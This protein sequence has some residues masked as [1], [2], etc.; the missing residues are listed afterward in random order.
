MAGL[1][2]PAGLTLTGTRADTW[3]WALSSVAAPSYIQSMIGTELYI[4]FCLAT[5]ALI[6]M[7]GPIVTLTIANS[8][9]YGTRVG[10]MT[11]AGTSVATT[12]LLLVGGLGM[13]SA[14]AL[15]AEWFEWLRWIGAAYLIWL[16]IQQWRAKP[17]TID[18]AEAKPAPRKNLFW[19][20]FV[21]SITNPK[22]ILFY[23]AFF[24]QFMDPAQAAGPQLFVLSATFLVIATFFDSCYALLCGRIRPWLKG[25]RRGRIR[26]HITGTLLVGTGLALAFA[27]RI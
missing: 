8:L 3:E 20:G 17:T 24:P 9:A 22:T 5:A 4:A 25:Q 19:Q 12:V 6:L 2:E 10:L 23:A 16:G 26:N 11:V 13:A 7:P 14:F 21:V 18:D 27:R 15:L 1:A